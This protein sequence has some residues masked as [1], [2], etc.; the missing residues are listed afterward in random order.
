MQ[1]CARCFVMRATTRVWNVLCVCEC[2][3]Y[4]TVA[5]FHC[6]SSC[7][8]T[9][10]NSLFARSHQVCVLTYTHFGRF[11]AHFT[12][13]LTYFLCNRRIHVCI[14][15]ILVHIHIMYISHYPCAVCG[16]WCVELAI[17]AGVV[18]RDWVREM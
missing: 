15:A 18:W 17:M 1:M 5:V 11:A 4:H 3:L 2:R 10:N 12:C 14:F 16:V 6:R 9:V 13:V 7:V 8:A